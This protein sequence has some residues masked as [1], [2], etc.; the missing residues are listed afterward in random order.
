MPQGIRV[1]KRPCRICRKWFKP[2]PRVGERQKTCGDQ[3]CQQ[4]WHTKQCSNWN[5]NNSA[6]FREIYLSKKLGAATTSDEV[7]QAVTDIDSSDISRAHSAKSSK[8]PIN[9][10]QEVIGAQHLV[11]IQYLTRLLFKRFQEEMQAQL[12]EITAEARRLPLEDI[13][14]GDSSNRSP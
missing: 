12:L 13:S 14:R 3:L 1:K 8:L 9:L 5:R 2:N 7:N 4:K 11:I 10:I 6:Y